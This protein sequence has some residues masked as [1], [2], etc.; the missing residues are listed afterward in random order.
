MKKLLALGLCV[1]F[2]ISMVSCDSQSSTISIYENVYDVERVEGALTW[3]EG[4]ALPSFA[5][6]AETIQAVNI[7]KENVHT[8]RLLVS[9]QG[10]V[11]RT[12]PRI[13]LC[14]GNENSGDGK[15]LTDEGVNYT[16]VED[17]NE[18]I[19]EYKDEINGLVIWDT[20]QIDTI[21]LA[22]TYAGIHNALAVTAKQADFYSQEPYNFTVLEDYTGDFDSKLEIYQYMYDYLWPDCTHRLLMGLGPNITLTGT[23]DLAIAAQCAI[24]YTNLNNPEEVALMER[25]LGDMRPGVDCFSGWFYDGNEL[26]LVIEYTVG[27]GNKTIE[28]SVSYIVL[29]ET[30]KGLLMPT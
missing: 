21:N 25:F 24:T 17:Y 20:K 12:Q 15:W 9:L 23:R 1:I 5:Y 18:L 29:I 26:N 14:D 30:H 8:K 4:Q 19:L 3:P 22:H 10:I 7:S 28:E 6:P 13:A 11:N 16:F 2:A 27:E